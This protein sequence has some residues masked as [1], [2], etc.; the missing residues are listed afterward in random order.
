M[1]EI[2]V[3]YQNWPDASPS[4]EFR[5]NLTQNFGSPH[6]TSTPL[7]QLAVLGKDQAKL[8]SVPSV[9]TS[10]AHTPVSSTS[11]ELI[12]IS[13]EEEPKNDMALVV[14][15]LSNGPSV[16]PFSPIPSNFAD[17]NDALNSTT[18][19]LPCDSEQRDDASSADLQLAVYDGASEK[20]SDPDI[21]I[22][23]ES[24]IAQ[25]RSKRLN[26]LELEHTMVPCAKKDWLK[27]M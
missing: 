1:N 21:T 24:I 23:S 6:L 25:G 10:R 12:D 9:P 5:N 4:V 19:V 3:R 20:R 11:P 2:S 17:L 15:K 8:F 14:K 16:T 18:E 7:P 26:S 13:Q 22:L 27:D